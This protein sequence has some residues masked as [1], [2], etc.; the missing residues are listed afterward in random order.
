MPASAFAKGK[1]VLGIPIAYF[2]RPFLML[3]KRF[4]PFCSEKLS[5]IHH[6][7]ASLKPPMIFENN[8]NRNIMVKVFLSIYLSSSIIKIA[9][10]QKCC[11]IS[12]DY[13]RYM[14]LG[15]FF[16]PLYPGLTF[17]IFLWIWK[18]MV[19]R[20]E[21]RLPH[22]KRQCSFRDLKGE[23]GGESYPLHQLAPSGKPTGNRAKVKLVNWLQM[24]LVT[25]WRSYVETTMPIT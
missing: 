3:D 4:F 11:N 13:V 16:D 12:K 9:L 22:W 23:G 2:I 17:W 6:S 8:E 15:T 10:K 25:D 24:S 1:Y 7:L 18:F 21:P 14:N 20:I 5:K 19:R